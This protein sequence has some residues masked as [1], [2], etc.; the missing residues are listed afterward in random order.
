V[1]LG[2]IWR[3]VPETECPEC[4]REIAMHE[5]ETRTVA[6][7]DEFETTYR[8]PYCGHDFEDPGALF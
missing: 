4:G 5:L 3:G 2:R 7:R 1:F 6:T 8:C